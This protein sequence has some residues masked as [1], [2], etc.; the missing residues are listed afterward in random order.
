MR[1]KKET[2]MTK[3]GAIAEYAAR[4][5]GFSDFL[6][7]GRGR[8]GRG[9]RRGGSAADRETNPAAGCAVD[10]VLKKARMPKA[11]VMRGA[12]A[13]KNGGFCRR[14]RRAWAENGH[15]AR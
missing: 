4:F 9:G 12:D 5:G 11:A 10:I 13:C 6:I 15:A 1:P 3:D 14:M 2:D 8:S 7:Y